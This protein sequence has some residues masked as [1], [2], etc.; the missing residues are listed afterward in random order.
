[1]FNYD[2]EDP[3]YIFHYTHEGKEIE[4]KTDSV[5]IVDLVDNIKSF[6]LASGWGPGVVRRIQVLEDEE[7]EELGIED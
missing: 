2:Y 1:M 7:L 4:M 6:L 5:Y 3:K